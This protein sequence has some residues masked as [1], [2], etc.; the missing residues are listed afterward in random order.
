LI[1]LSAMA[2]PALAEYTSKQLV[3]A[4]GKGAVNGLDKMAGTGRANLP[5]INVMHQLLESCVI[6]KGFKFRAYDL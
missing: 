5:G 1:S 6:E 4:C 2:T 3:D